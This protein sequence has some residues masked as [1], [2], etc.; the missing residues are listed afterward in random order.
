M[1][2]GYA[3]YSIMVLRPLVKGLFQNNLF[4]I[5]DV[6]TLLESI[7]R[8]RILA[9]EATGDVVD[10][11]ALL[12]CG[13]VDVVG[14]LHGHYAGGLNVTSLRGDDSCTRCYGSDG[15]AEEAASYLAH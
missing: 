14:L 10:G 7:G 2:Y 3:G 4:T 5:D 11:E 13:S 15:L 9:Y 6:D 12:N 8:H 1:P